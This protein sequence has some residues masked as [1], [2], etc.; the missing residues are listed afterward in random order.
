ME[1]NPEM[2][3]K[4]GGLIGNEKRRMLVRRECSFLIEKLVVNV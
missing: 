3:S 2:S 4:G 1:V